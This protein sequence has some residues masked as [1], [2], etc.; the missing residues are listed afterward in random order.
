LPIFVTSLR[1]PGRAAELG[2]FKL[3]GQPARVD[4]RLPEQP[5]DLIEPRR[6]IVAEPAGIA[7]ICGRGDAVLV[8]ERGDLT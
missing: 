2:P 6:F 7:T 8:D 4:E 5:P 3:T 1:E